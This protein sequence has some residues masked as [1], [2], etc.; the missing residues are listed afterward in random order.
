MST[1]E[2]EKY[3]LAATIRHSTRQVW[4]RKLGKVQF[5]LTRYERL[6][7]VSVPLPDNHLLLIS[8][9]P[10]TKN[11]DSLMS[12]KVLPLLDRDE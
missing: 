11:I 2:T 12:D 4:E 9:D 1:E 3:A 8:I 6:W 10:E 5:T 7:R